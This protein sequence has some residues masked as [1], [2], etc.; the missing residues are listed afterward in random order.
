MEHFIDEYQQKYAI[1][2]HT[3]GEDEVTFRD[4][5]GDCA[6]RKKGYQKIEFTCRQ[7]LED[8]LAYAWVDTC[9]I[10]KSSSAELSEAINSMW[11]FYK[12]AVVCYAF[13]SDAPEDLNPYCDTQTDEMTADARLEMTDYY[14][15]MLHGCRWF[16]RGWTLQELIAP[17]DVWFYGKGWRF[18]GTRTD[19][20]GPICAIIGINPKLFD[21]SFR[22]WNTQDLFSVATRMSMGCGP[23]HFARRRSCILATRIVRS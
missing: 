16:W 9:C 11:S 20:R 23:T 19:L 4:M 14:G 13:L 15:R 5:Q 6:E 17:M 7:A 18:F 1:L 12:T 3:W 8:D 22:P 21:P 10:D 2:S